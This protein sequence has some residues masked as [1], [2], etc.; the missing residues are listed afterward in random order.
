MCMEAKFERFK[1]WLS[2]KEMVVSRE[3]SFQLF[4][5]EMKEK[6]DN[7]EEQEARVRIFAKKVEN[8]TTEVRERRLSRKE[9][10]GMDLTCCVEKEKINEIR[11]C[12][13]KK[14]FSALWKTL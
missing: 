4:G 13:M 9:W 14:N 6:K 1:E 10:G 2:S 5:R 12:K 11:L 7:G 3:N 8:F